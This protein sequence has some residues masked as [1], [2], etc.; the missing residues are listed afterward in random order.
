M[1]KIAKKRIFLIVLI[2]FFLFCFYKFKNNNN[3]KLGSTT[4]TVLLG[5]LIPYEKKQRGSSGNDT[6]LSDIKRWGFNE[7]RV[8]CKAGEVMVRLGCVSYGKDTELW[9]GPDREATCYAQ[10]KKMNVNHSDEMKE[11]YPRIKWNDIDTFSQNDWGKELNEGD[12]SGSPMLGFATGR[13]NRQNEF[14]KMKLRGYWYNLKDDKKWKGASSC[15]NGFLNKDQEWGDFAERKYRNGAWVNCP[16]NHYISS[17][18]F[19]HNNRGSGGAFKVKCCT[20]V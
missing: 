4:G 5:N 15:V 20:P 14:K 13:L 8:L 1:K 6:G 9:G 3:K 19:S 16:E 18:W 17:I 11:K 7:S 12:N 10:C 2:I